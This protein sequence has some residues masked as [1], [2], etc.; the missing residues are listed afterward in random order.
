[1][2]SF[3]ATQTD[4]IETLQEWATTQ[5][6]G[7]SK[8]CCTGDDRL[9]ARIATEEGLDIDISE[10]IEYLKR[11]QQS[12]DDGCSA[13]QLEE[14]ISWRGGDHYILDLVRQDQPHY[15]LISLVLLGRCNYK[16]AE[17]LVAL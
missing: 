14:D 1:M 5:A 4:L 16:Q 13:E 3:Q 15:A 17:K 6:E 7:F 12:E 2:G 11:E 9:A 10:L 8:A